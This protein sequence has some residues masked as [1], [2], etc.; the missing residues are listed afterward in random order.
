MR[1]L[2]G[3][4]YELDQGEIATTVKTGTIVLDTN[5]FLGLYRLNESGRQA[6]LK[7]LN[8][9][10]D[11]LW[12]PY[13]VALEF[14]RN[15]L[16]V[17][18][19][20]SKRYQELRSTAEKQFEAISKSISQFRDDEIT[21]EL[22]NAAKKALRKLNRK[23]DKLESA[24]AI[25]LTTARKND[26]VRAAIDKLFP[27]ENI[28]TK[29]TVE[30]LAELKKTAKERGLNAVPPGFKD[31][32]KKDD[33]SGDYIVWSEM[34]DY[35]S[36]S[37]RPL[38]FV[39]NDSAGDDWYHRVGG[40]T[41]GPLQALRNEMAQ[42]SDYAYHQTTIVG[43]I[44][45]ANEHLDAKVDNKTID[46]VEHESAASAQRALQTRLLTAEEANAIDFNALRDR[47]IEA[48]LMGSAAQK[49]AGS[50]LADAVLANRAA[51]LGPSMKSF[52][53]AVRDG[54]IAASGMSALNG[55]T[56]LKYSDLMQAQIDASVLNGINAMLTGNVGKKKARRIDPDQDDDND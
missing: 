22:G 44:K 16:K 19:D 39:T 10:S 53:D 17:V 43:F 11:R 33:P 55:V 13:Q 46:L 50:R 27:K 36:T 51:T 6:V 9:A 4:W 30:Q 49:A 5:V 31:F 35:K 52:T 8:A 3:E 29:P 20:E 45:L 25:S 37:A 7:V 1:E 26:P 23:I 21:M 47:A 42:A 2:F 24:H 34:L 18:S 54:Q 14:Q 32:E 41:T 48:G 40:Q 56:A 38:L 12:M 15:R 28:G